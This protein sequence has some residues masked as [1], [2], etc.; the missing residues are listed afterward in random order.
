MTQDLLIVEIDETKSGAAR[1]Y[2]GR[3]WLVSLLAILAA[4]LGWNAV[5]FM[6]VHRALAGETDASM[7][8]YRRWLISSSQIVVDVRSV[9]GNQSMVGMDRMLFKSAEALQNQ[10]FDEIALASGGKTRFLMDGSYFQEIGATFQTQNPVYTMRTMQ[11]HLKN[12]DGTP[13]FGAWSGGWL[14]VLGQQMEDHNEFHQRWWLR[15]F[16][17]L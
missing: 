14:G 11:E 17:E 8:V 5:V 6:P 12:P 2:R 1:R 15:D 10:S 9:E 13:A 16:A 4:L 3:V 7:I